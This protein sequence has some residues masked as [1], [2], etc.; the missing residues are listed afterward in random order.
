MENHFNCI[1]MYE[2]KINGKIY[3]GQAINFNKRHS[4]HCKPS[5]K[6]TYIDRALK[7]Y[8]KDN[9][10]IYILIENL[11]SQ[12]ELNFYEKLFIEQYDSLAKNG[13][14]YNITNGGYSHPWKNKTEEEKDIIKQKISKKSKGKTPMLGKKHS[15]ETKEKIKKNNARSMLNKHHTKETR[16][17]MSKNST[18]KKP[19]NQYDLDGN[20]IKTW[21]SSSAII[22]YYGYATSSNIRK[23]C[24]YY[25]NPEKFMKTNK[26]PVKW[27]YGYIWKF[28]NEIND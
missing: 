18:N 3:I 10:D 14:G 25:L 6:N 23:C 16:D 11:E 22:K 21:E 26:R 4:D 28:K 2:N 5:N 15:I 17:K 24:N 7:K 13:N 12:E 9:F 8:G 19:I 27:A 1:Y 20:F